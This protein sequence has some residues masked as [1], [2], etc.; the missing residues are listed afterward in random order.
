MKQRVVE[1]FEKLFHFEIREPLIPYLNISYTV[2]VSAELNVWLRY[3]PSSDEIKNT[4]FGIATYK[5]LGP[6]G[7]LGDFLKH[8]W[9]LIKEDLMAVVLFF[10][11]KRHM[12]KVL[13]HTF[14]ILVTEKEALTSLNDY[15]LISCV[16]TSYKVIAKILANHIAYTLLDLI[17]C[18]QTT[19]D[20]NK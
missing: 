6:D 18:N 16:S 1:H 15:S 11:Q 3:F 8:H 4:L 5:A 9:M 12:L 14:V 20:K 17:S 7:V 2:R 19:F 13:N 10:F